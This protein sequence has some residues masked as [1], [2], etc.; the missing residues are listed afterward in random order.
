ME[1]QAEMFE[2]NSVGKEEPLSFLLGSDKGV[3]G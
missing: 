3:E 2:L 1:G